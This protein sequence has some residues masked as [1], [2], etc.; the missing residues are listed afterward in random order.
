M[1][2][3]AVCGRFSGRTCSSTGTPAISTAGLDDA[4]RHTWSLGVEE[5]FYFV[6]P[7]MLDAAWLLSRRSLRAVAAV[8]II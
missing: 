7:A 1:G 5:Q 4:V 2:D 8:V 6:W 3:S